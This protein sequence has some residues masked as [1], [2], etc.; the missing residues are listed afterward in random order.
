LF[1]SHDVHFIRSLAD[2][3]LHISAGKLT[4]YA[5][6][7]DYYLDKTQA[8]SA[9]AA[10]TAGEQLSDHRAGSPTP[11]AQPATE[12]AA[13]SPTVDHGDSRA[14]SE[15]AAKGGPGMRE[16]REARKREAAERTARAKAR[17][18]RENAL[19]EAEARVAQLEA[20][21]AELVAALEDPK[22]YDDPG[23]AL[24]LNR[25]LNDLSREIASATE[26]WEGLA[27]EITAETP[28]V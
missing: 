22:S 13:P 1:I 24:R 4:P 28:G 8:L 17:R 19:A 26:H 21:Q 5:G 16:V 11:A 12:P 3:V 25:E 9:R 14:A 7:Y 6:N 23:L 18:E 20:R 15:A 10:L 27:S 2:S